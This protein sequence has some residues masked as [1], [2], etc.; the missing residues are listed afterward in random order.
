VRYRVEQPGRPLIW[1]GGR[2]GAAL[3]RSPEDR[4]PR[5]ASAAA[6]PAKVWPVLLLLRT[7]ASQ[8][9]LIKQL[10]GPFDSR[11]C[12]HQTRPLCGQPRKHI[13]TDAVGAAGRGHPAVE[14]GAWACFG[15][16]TGSSGG[17]ICGSHLT[18]RWREMDSNHRSRHERAGFCCGRRIAGPSAGSQKGLFFY[19]VPMVRIR[20]PPVVNPLRLGGSHAAAPDFWTAG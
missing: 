14:D 10:P 5:W 13:R 8:V 11:F 1:E 2:A 12:R 9:V 4:V 20:L 17:P 3:H 18:H 6:G 16:A 7:T 15:G 19:A